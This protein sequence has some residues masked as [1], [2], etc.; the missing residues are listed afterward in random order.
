MFELGVA[1]APSTLGVVG[2]QDAEPD[3]EDRD[4]VWI[5]TVANAPAFPLMWVFF[6]GAWIAKFPSAASSGIIVLY[7][8]SAASVDTL[9]GGA[10]GAVTTD[11]GPFWEI[12]ASMAGRVPIG[13]GTLQPSTT[14]LNLGDT[15]GADEHA[16]T[17]AEMPAHVHRITAHGTSD[18]SNGNGVIGGGN[19]TTGPFTYDDT[20]V[21]TSNHLSIESQGGGAELNLLPPYRALHFIRRT[22]R[23]YATQPIA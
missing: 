11:S 9:D 22:A 21:S 23:V 1:V 13:V 14:P 10:A 17:V 16:I 20:A 4:K 5:R 12:V 19:G 3:V 18:P 7:E 15:G 6:N 2:P 8:G